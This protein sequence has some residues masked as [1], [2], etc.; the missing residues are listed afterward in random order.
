MKYLNKN[1][2]SRYY[3]CGRILLL[4]GLL[5]FKQNI[6]QGQDREF[7]TAEASVPPI[8]KLNIE[9]TK[10]FPAISANDYNKGYMDLKD[11]V[12]LSVSSNIPWRVVIYTHKVNLYVTPG[13]L[14]SIEHFQ[15]RSGNTP[16][17]SIYSNPHT[18]I[19]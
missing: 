19:Y 9:D 1:L 3:L 18:V 12:I 15:W 8:Q 13:R 2:N 11:A 7:F 6:L 17:R 16:F 4:L 5:L 10:L 14:K